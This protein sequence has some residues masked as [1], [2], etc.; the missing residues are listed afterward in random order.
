MLIGGGGGGGHAGGG[1]C[2]VIELLFE[3]E[4]CFDFVWLLHDC[5]H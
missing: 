3:L 2:G 1:V 4:R 5:K